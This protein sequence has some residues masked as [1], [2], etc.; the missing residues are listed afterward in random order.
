LGDPAFSEQLLKWWD[1]HG[2]KDLPWQLP[3]S[4]YRVWVSEIMLQQTQVKTVIPY[5][6]RFMDRF[7]DVQSLAAASTDDVLACWSGL[8]Y[9]ARARNLL[10]AAKACRDN[11][12]TKLPQTPEAL[13][14]LPGIGES[15]ANAIYSQAYDKPAVI[16]DGNVKRVLARY[17][18]IEGWPGK[19]S[20]HN[21]LWETAGQL[22][23]AN[24]GANFTQAIMDLGATLCTRARPDCE[25]CPVNDNCKAL[26]DGTVAFFPS[27]RPRLKITKK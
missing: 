12:G 2:R 10:K 1:L 7:P 11:H 22:L 3:R 20:I 19:S 6:N 14:A 27:P 26:R 9:Y 8:G 5:F 16:L 17:F 13:L 21:F 15:T 23:P 24:R 18:A 25:K 4:P